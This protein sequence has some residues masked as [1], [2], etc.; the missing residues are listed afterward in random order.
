MENIPQINFT[1]N[2]QYI[3]DMSFEG[4]A[5]PADVVTHE[6][7]NINVNV[8]AQ[9]RA[10]DKNVFEVVLNTSAQATVQGKNAF[11]I[12]LSYAGVTTVPEGIPES[13][14][15]YVLLAEVP[16]HLFPFARNIISNATRDGGFPPLML[17][18]IDF[19]ALY[20]QQQKEADKPVAGHA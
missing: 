20:A 7:P 8:T 19:H 14:L 10:L 1:I 2:A 4:P 16:R 15:R 3:K 18:P 12:E 6:T 5:N 11:M 9:T 17:Q 13:A